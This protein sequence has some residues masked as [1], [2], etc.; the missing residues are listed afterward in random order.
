MEG[1]CCY[2]FIYNIR[3]ILLLNYHAK[4]NL[5]KKPRSIRFLYRIIK[6]ILRPFVIDIIT[7]DI[8]V[9]GDRKRLHVS[10][11]ARMVNTL[12]N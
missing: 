11:K 3:N 6:V 12:F 7:N 5:M 9:F 1:F 8:R 4:V 10:H 2:T